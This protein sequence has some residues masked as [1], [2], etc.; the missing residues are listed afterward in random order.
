M[1]DL[2][3]EEKVEWLELLHRISTA[4][5]SERNRD[6][7]IELILEEA[8]SICNADGGTLYL[9]T[10]QDELRFTFL[11]NDSL[12]LKLGGTTEREIT[13][14]SLAMF[15]SVTG[16]PNLKNVATY[17][18]IAKHSVNIPDAYNARGFDFSGT[19]TF[20]EHHRYRSASFLTIPLVNA[21][22]YVIGVLQLINARDPNNLSVLPFADHHQR[23]VETLAAQAAVALDNQL[24]FEGQRELLE[25]FIKAI[26]AAIDAKSPYTGGHCRR[27][28][29]LTVMLTEAACEEQSGPFK[30][31][32]LSEEE[33]YEL[34]I[35][36]WMHDCGKVTTPVH[37][38]DKATKLETICDRIE[39]V[40]ARF[41]VLQRDA[42]IKH[43]ERV[44]QGDSQANSEKVYEQ[45]L[46]NLKEDQSFL[47]QAN[48][49][50]EFLTPEAR[51]R[52]EALSQHTYTRDGKKL[53]LLNKD[54][55]ENL[56]VTRGTL[57]EHERLVIN[58]HMVETIRLLDALPFPRTLRRVSEYAGG[59]HERMDG[60]GYPKG[61]F[62]AD[63]SI[64]ARIMAIA[65]VFEALTAQ[66]RPYK[67]G[68]SLSES[69]EIM[70]RMKRDNHLDPQLFDLFVKR[71][72]Y[73]T[74]AERFLPEE[75]V[76]PVD[77]EA[78]LAFEPKGFDVPPAEERRK[79]MKV[80][81]DAYGD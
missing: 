33:W 53:S 14:P 26:A 1:A 43:L 7:L 72:V 6:R 70:G 62:A 69:M 49:G 18:A 15:D 29:E 78:L 46:C 76:E 5:S 64:P 56:T 32:A 11:V 25:S 19:V 65:D 35:A 55:L 16:A 47:E 27:V 74:Y 60:T 13:L 58:R 41:D 37:V 8:R 57:S 24:L 77:E 38:M 71:H 68:L 28:P 39:L 73:R 30:D 61:I 44:Q 40:K 34:R 23:I 52:I 63:M 54:E 31:F 48:L 67:R 4:L 51:A 66:D 3:L 79:R 20:D 81:L 22:S 2:S 9:R 17:A 36:A 12:G 80:F 42:R 50:V 45:E 59:H 10:D 21:E 75:L